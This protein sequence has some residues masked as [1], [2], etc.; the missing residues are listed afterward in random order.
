MRKLVDV[1]GDDDVHA[2]DDENSPELA[3]KRSSSADDVGAL[4]AEDIEQ[5]RQISSLLSA[6]QDES[7]YY[8]LCFAVFLVLGLS[9]FLSVYLSKNLQ[10]HSD[11]LKASQFNALALSMT[12]NIQSLIDVV[13]STAAHGY[14]SRAHH[15]SVKRIDVP[16]SNLFP[17]L[18]AH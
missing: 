10:S 18:C 8:Y 14:I 6:K 13:S 16:H 12:L 17:P 1:S 9:L 7:S 11:T 3:S 15:L 4:S 5:T 2:S